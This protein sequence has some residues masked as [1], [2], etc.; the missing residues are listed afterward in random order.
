MQKFILAQFRGHPA[1]VKYMSLFMISER[2]DPSQLEGMRGRLKKTED[3]HA[4]SVSTVS[5]LEAS[6]TTLKRNY[7]NLLNDVKLLKTKVK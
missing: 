2:V 6:N 1:I 3:S 7:N 4:A 5:R